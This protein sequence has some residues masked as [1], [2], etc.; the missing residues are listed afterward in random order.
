MISLVLGIPPSCFPF[1]SSWLCCHSVSKFLITITKSWTYS[2]QV[3]IINNRGCESDC[4][5]AKKKKK[6]VM[7][8][9]KAATHMTRSGYV[10]RDHWSHTPV[11]PPV[12]MS[13]PVGSFLC[14]MV[15]DRFL[16]PAC[17]SS[18]FHPASCGA[19]LPFG[20]YLLISSAEF[21]AV[22]DTCVT[23]AY[24]DYHMWVATLFLYITFF[25]FIT[26]LRLEMFTFYIYLIHVERF[27]QSLRTCI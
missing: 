2:L 13:L 15:P 18:S 25:F 22:E 19:L 10:F 11:Q 23:W 24:F 27:S 16:L 14:F 8:K 9:N 7:Y 12:L 1:H 4:S 6:K 17:W 5:N 26:T 21:L 20:L 3:F